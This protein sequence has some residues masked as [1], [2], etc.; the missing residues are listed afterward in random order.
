MNASYSGRP[1]SDTAFC[2]R[3]AASPGV[4]L[5]RLPGDQRAR[6]VRGHRR[7]EVLA[8]GAQVDRQRVDPALVDREHPVLVAGEVRV[9]VG[10][11]PHPGVRGVEQVRAVAVDLYPG[12]RLPLAVGVPADVLAPF[13]DEHA[14]AEVTGAPFGDG[15]AEEAGPD[16][17]EVDVHRR[18]G[19]GGGS[20]SRARRPGAA[21]RLVDPGG[22]RAAPGGLPPCC[23][24]RARR[25]RC[26]ARRSGGTPPGG[27]A[28]GSSGSRRGP[29]RYGRTRVR[30]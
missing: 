17:D 24:R 9:L 30:R 20:R 29:A 8:D 1:I 14:Q 4:H 10:V 19:S 15:Q 22:F 27:T 3:L 11:L 28:R 2:S 5:G 16:D 13:Q 6:L 7:A 21:C 26:S 25:A 12:L 23:C 18:T